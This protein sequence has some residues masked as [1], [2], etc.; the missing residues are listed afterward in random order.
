VRKAFL[1]E[2]LVKVFSQ[3]IHVACMGNCGIQLIDATP[4]QASFSSQGK[5][6]HAYLMSFNYI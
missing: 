5:R 2:S 3:Q 6:S 1:I 4:V